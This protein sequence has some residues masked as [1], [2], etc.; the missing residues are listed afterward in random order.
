MHESQTKPVLRPAHGG[1][2]LRPMIGSI[3][4]VLDDTPGAAAARDL[5]FAIARRT[6]AAVTGVFVLDRPHTTDLHEPVPMGGGAFAA[7][8]NKRLAAELEEEAAQVLA[9]ARAA[10]GDLPF[11]IHTRQEAPEPALLAEGAQHDLIIIGRDGTLGREACDAGLSPTVE[12]LI[13]DGVRPL[14]VVPP[15]AGHE[16]DGPALIGYHSSMAGMRTVQLFA[17]LGLGCESEVRLLDFSPGGACVEG[18][19]AYLAR[20][21]CTVHASVETGDEHDT[22]LAEARRL[23]ARMMVMGA[24]QENGLAR[25]VFGSATARLLRAAPCPVFIHG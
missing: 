23:P 13:R 14:L 22:L 6:G 1:G 19:G 7:Q 20:H 17:L 8:R 11:E 15:G 3:L 9:A 5:A 21:G 24:D 25:L 16:A 18:I 12:A 2:N 10:A 4:L